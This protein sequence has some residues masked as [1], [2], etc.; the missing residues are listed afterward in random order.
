MRTKNVWR[1]PEEGYWADEKHAF[2]E[3]KSGQIADLVL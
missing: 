1:Y 2:D 3:N